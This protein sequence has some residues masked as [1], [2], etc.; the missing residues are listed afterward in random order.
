MTS[1]VLQAIEESPDLASVATSMQHTQDNLAL[2]EQALETGVYTTIPFVA[3]NTN[4]LA[5]PEVQRERVEAWRLDL[6]ELK[7]LHVR[8]VWS[9]LQQESVVVSSA[10]SNQVQEIQHGF[11]DLEDAMEQAASTLYPDPEPAIRAI[12]DPAE[13]KAAF[14]KAAQE[15]KTELTVTR[16]TLQQRQLAVIAEE[17]KFQELADTIRIRES[18]L[19]QNTSKVPEMMEADTWREEWGEISQVLYGGI[20]Q[21]SSSAAIELN[22]QE[23]CDRLRQLAAEWPSLMVPVREAGIDV[24]DSWASVEEPSDCSQEQVLSSLHRLHRTSR[25][26][27]SLVEARAT[28]IRQEI[29][30]ENPELLGLKD[31]ITRLHHDLMYQLRHHPELAALFAKENLLVATSRRMEA[32]QRKT[33]FELAQEHT[34]VG[35]GPT[36]HPTRN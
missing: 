16:I 31:E 4:I 32:L 25:R 20:N 10:I 5:T 36:A 23:Y 18:Q 8:S 27:Q 34:S 26:I 13:R 6:M 24:P 9:R 3:S 22:V 7:K 19:Y 30:T 1:L 14:A 15:A 12:Q 11:D 17:P 35:N 21:L 28:R 2:V 33:Q 29:E